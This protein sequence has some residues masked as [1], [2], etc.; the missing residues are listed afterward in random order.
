[1][2]MAAA[3]VLARHASPDRKTIMDALGGVLCRCT[4]YLKIVEAVLDAAKTGPRMQ[5]EPG[6][7]LVLQPGTAV[8]HRVLR[9]DGAPK[10]TGAAIFGDDGA[11][12]DALWLKAVRSPHAHARFSIGDLAPF[13][14]RNP[15]IVRVF[16]ARDVPGENS[17]GIYPDLK[18]QPVFAEALRAPSRRAGAGAGGRRMKL[19]R[20]FRRRT[21]RS[22]GSRCPPSTAS[23]RRW[24]TGH[25][26][27]TPASPTTS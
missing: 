15:G 20:R 19:S 7:A 4:G 5:E 23:R 6:P 1:M 17:F 11:P 27:S 8:G 3:D 22:S 13:L 14:H 25:R 21:F 9:I 10:L 26:P 2:L 16:T 18:D 24:P 12:A